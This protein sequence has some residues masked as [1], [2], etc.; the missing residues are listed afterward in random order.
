MMLRPYDVP[1]GPLEPPEEPEPRSWCELC[2][3]WAD[4]HA[5]PGWG[6]CVYQHEWTQPDPADVCYGFE[7]EWPE[8]PDPPGCEW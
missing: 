3:L 5:E 7:G 6:Y 8:P 2:P 4:E 1:D